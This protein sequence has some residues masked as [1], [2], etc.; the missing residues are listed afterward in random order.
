LFRHLTHYNS[1]DMEDEVLR[2]RCCVVQVLLVLC[3]KSTVF[4]CHIVFIFM[5]M[6]SHT[7]ASGDV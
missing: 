4:M 2:R 1:E 3:S 5:G 6:F 7:L